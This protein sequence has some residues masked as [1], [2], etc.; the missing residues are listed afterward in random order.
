MA[1]ETSPEDADDICSLPQ[2]SDRLCVAACNSPESITLSGDADAIQEAKVIFDDEGKFARQLR[3]DKAYHS[4][5]MMLCSEPYYQSLRNAGV[6]ARTPSESCKWYSSVLEGGLV[7]ENVAREPLS[8]R[9]WCDNL[10]GQVKFASALQAALKASSMDLNIVLEVGPHGA[11]K[12]PILDTIKAIGRAKIS[13]VSCMTRNQDCRKTFTGAI[14]ELW[15]NG[16]EAMLSFPS[17][18]KQLSGAAG[19]TYGP[20]LVRDLPTYQW[21]HDRV[22]WHESRRSKLL[23]SRSE[24]G[25]NLLG[26][27]SPDST[28]SDLL[29]HNVIKMSSVPWLSGHAVQGQLVFP[30]AGYVALA[31][32]AALR[33]PGFSTTAP[34]LIE[35]R[36]VDI[37]RAITFADE[38]SAVEMLFSLHVGTQESTPDKS[39]V[40]T[41]TF[42][43]HSSS[44]EGT[45]I[46][47]AGGQLVITYAASEEIDHI[48]M[49]PRQGDAPEYLVEVNEEEFYSRLA[50]LGYEYSGP[51]KALSKI[52]RKCGE[53]RG[54]VKKPE[55]PAD[56][57]SSLLV[58]PGLLDATFQSVFLALSFP[59]DGAL[60]TL[61]VP[62]SIERLVVDVAAWMANTDT[63]LAF[64]AQITSSSAQSGMVGEIGM[65][66]KDGG[67][68]L[69]QLEGFRAV[70]LAGATAQDDID[71]LFES[72]TGVAFPDGSLAVG[73]DVATEEET[74]VAWLMERISCFYLR[75]MTRDITREQEASAA[76]HHQLFMEYARHVAAEVSAGRHPYGKK[77][78]M[79]DT[80][81]SLATLME[82]YKERVEVRLACTVGENIKSAILG[83]THI[84]APMRQDGLL[85][86]YYAHDLGIAAATEFLAEV[87]GQIVH[88]Y[89][90]MQILEIGAGTGGATKRVLPRIG[91]A[92]D[93]YTFTDI[94]AG[95][96]ETARDV[97]AEYE[98]RMDFRVLDLEKDVGHQGFEE[99]SFDLIIASL[100]L[101]ATKDLKQTLQ[102]VRK[103]LRPGGY[104]VA[105][106]TTNISTIRATFL[107]GG[108]DGWWLGAES[109]RQWSPNVTS[110]EWHSLM[111]DAGFTGIETST[112]ERDALARPCSVLVTRASNEYVDV[113]AAPSMDASPLSAIDRLLIITGS[114]LEAVRAAR[115]ICRRIAPHCPDVKVVSSFAELSEVDLRGP[116][117]VLNLSDWEEPLFQDLTTAAF[118]GLQLLFSHVETLMW[119]T[120]GCRRDQPY[121]NVSHGFVRALAR[122]N[123]QLSIRIIDFESDSLLQPSVLV[124]ELLRQTVLHRAD[125]DGVDLLWNAETEMTVDARGCLSVERVKPSKYFNNCYNAA[126][127]NVEILLDPKDTPVR[128]TKDGQWARYSPPGHSLATEHGV[129]I[130][131]LYSSGSCI[132]L[133][134]DSMLYPCV[135]IEADSGRMV[136]ALASD[137]ASAIH[138]PPEHTAPF[139]CDSEEALVLLVDLAN[140]LRA[141]VIVKAAAASPHGTILVVEPSLGLARAL[142]RVAARDSLSV[143]CVT[144][145]VVKM[146]ELKGLTGLRLVHPRASS[147]ALRRQ[148]PRG[149]AYV[150][151]MADG[152]LLSRRL[153]AAIDKDVRMENFTKLSFHGSLPQI[154]HRCIQQAKSSAP[155]PGPSHVLVQQG[156]EFSTLPRDADAVL[157][158]SGMGKIAVPINYTD[159]IPSLRGDRTYL[160]IGLAGRN[161]LGISIVEF[162]IRQGA[163]HV[164]LTSRRPSPNQKWIDHYASQGVKIQI[165]ANDVTDEDAVRSLVRHIRTTGPPIAGVANAALVLHDSMFLTMTYE[166]MTDALRPKVEGSRILDEIFWRDDL[167]FFIMFSSLASTIGAPGQVNYAAAVSI[168]SSSSISMC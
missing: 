122:G 27:L 134:P 73:D 45:T 12:K 52:V 133:T 158:W 121:A 120:R 40:I 21:D 83:E 2:F 30:A 19:S 111:L 148:L 164:V 159:A 142:A 93:H 87:M 94:S 78:W 96:F 63:H 167:D 49:L 132:R 98:Q 101:H 55:Q 22:F 1:V 85:D 86:E 135:G 103:L 56:Y 140:G 62:V 65:Y 20:K 7:E 25:H 9:Y 126:R 75:Q 100:V 123:A 15:K 81:E 17:L 16:A 102:N 112:P 104:L 48:P 84:I 99:H 10:T 124:D 157:D 151:D 42:R 107:M 31:I 46:F 91:P 150:V 90:H 105:T 72:Q 69:L 143:V 70:P 137:M 149:I 168:T 4:Q 163:K 68:G 114:S 61:H 113:L 130:R 166:Q 66:S 74:A 3:V 155:L 39:R 131:P 109:G 80:K 144:A 106:E 8:G 136:M 60:W 14:G 119:V 54:Y 23:R 156:Q 28:E 97:F 76:W 24:P 125:R 71:L 92:F 118:Q 139:P 141:E 43:V 26:T 153:Y 79:V 53:G 162:M 50:Q 127:R 115:S 29:W 67:Q 154:W 11:L 147:S 146:T 89:P 165:I 77:E 18:E 44:G 13:Y 33:A 59:G 34:S 116:P 95:Y 145:S 82:P 161:G 117:T 47:N 36:D 58:H 110:A 41:T 128:L 160:L 51:F 5:H 32:E 57:N 108:L 38:R 138:V 35:I 37:G 152:S 129:L 88:V 64:D 6:H